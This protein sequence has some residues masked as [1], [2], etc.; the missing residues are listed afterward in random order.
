MAFFDSLP[1]MPANVMI[2][3]WKGAGLPTGHP[4][5]GLLDRFGWHGQR[6]EGPEA[7][8]PL[9]FGEPGALF[10]VDPALAPIGLIMRWAGWSS[11]PPSRR[12]PGSHS[13]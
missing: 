6:F 1:P 3:A 11:R 10:S 7:V 9:V 5:D 13:R 12:S 4:L 8:H 2:G